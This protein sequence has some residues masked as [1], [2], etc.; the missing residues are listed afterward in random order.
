MDYVSL[1]ESLA[2][3]PLTPAV[4]DTIQDEGL[5]EEQDA[6]LASQWEMAVFPLSAQDQAALKAMTDEV[7]E[8]FNAFDIALK[9]RWNCAVIDLIDY[10]RGQVILVKRVASRL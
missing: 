1:V 9:E 6:P 2:F 5:D 10:D 7:L 3:Y 8:R 4:W